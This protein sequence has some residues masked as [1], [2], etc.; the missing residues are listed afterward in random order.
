MSTVVPQDTLPAPVAPAPEPPRG[1]YGVLRVL[2]VGVT[3]LLVLGSV[4]S[5]APEM[6]Q[7]SEDVELAWPEGATTIQIDGDAGDV[8]VRESSAL[9]PVVAL[10]QSW[11]FR[12]PELRTSTEDGVMRV[13][14]ECPTGVL[15]RCS[16]DWSVVVPEGTAVGVSTS[17][18][19]VELVGVTGDVTVTTSVGHVRLSGAPTTADLRSSVGGVTAVL[20]EPADLLRVDSSVGDIDLTLPAGEAYDVRTDGGMSE[21]S[22]EVRVN[23]ASD[24]K[25]DVRTS[26]GSVR[27]DDE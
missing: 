15:T 4:L 9:G 24:Y 16:G 25:V 21:V 17:A 20:T 27:I 22:T 18:G 2:G 5:L 11:S 13:S 23:A 26:V 8:L 6:V 1:G 19:D 14:L 12:Q 7:R 10:E 3:G